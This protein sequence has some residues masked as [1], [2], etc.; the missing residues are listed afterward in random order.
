MPQSYAKLYYHIVFGTKDRVPQIS[1]EM[2]PRLYE[3][4]S[5]IF[6]NKACILAKAG[7]IADHV[8]LLAILS[9]EVSLSE[10][11]RDVKTNSS[12][13][14]HDT[15]PGAEQFA[16]QRGY[17]AFTVGYRES[18]RVEKYIERQKEHHRSKTFQEEFVELL[19][20][21]DVEYDPQFLW[22]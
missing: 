22:E 19:D 10:M 6:R 1:D 9:R 7:G 12:K 8:H 17:G 11:M 16:W 14:I 15:F 20:E 13:W 18:G 2:A 5:G 21:H 3:Y 4:F